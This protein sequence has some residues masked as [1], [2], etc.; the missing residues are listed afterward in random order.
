MG[1]CSFSSFAVYTNKIIIVLLEVLRKVVVLCFG[2][3]LA[4]WWSVSSAR[5]IGGVLSFPRARD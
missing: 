3:V 1:R 5:P 2:G 4:G